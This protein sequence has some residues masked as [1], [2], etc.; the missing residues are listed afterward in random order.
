KTRRRVRPWTLQVSCAE[1]PAGSQ[2]VKLLGRFVDEHDAACVR[3]ILKL[4][5]RNLRV[6]GL[7]VEQ[8]DFCGL[9]AI[10]NLR[11]YTL[12]VC[13]WRDKF[14]EPAPLFILRNLG[15]FRRQLFRRRPLT[16]E[17]TGRQPLLT[18]REIVCGTTLVVEQRPLSISHEL[19]IRVWNYRKD[20]IAIHAQQNRRPVTDKNLRR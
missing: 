4:R 5:V 2:I 20:W 17:F 7:A 11:S 12:C 16:I 15:H 8:N 1:P 14:F 10:E 9:V 18:D 19:Q 13:W 6:N 3:C